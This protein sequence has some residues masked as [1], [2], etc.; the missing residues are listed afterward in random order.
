MSDRTSCVLNP[1]GRYYDILHKTISQDYQDNY[2]PDDAI[3]MEQNSRDFVSRNSRMNE[4]AERLC[5]RLKE[6]S[7]SKCLAIF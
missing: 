6:S 7:I 1:R 5:Q 3:V 2:W 4:S